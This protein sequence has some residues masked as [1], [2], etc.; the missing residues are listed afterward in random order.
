M[1]A[2]PS[3][4]IGAQL[5]IVSVV[6]ASKPMK[7]DLAGPTR[8]RGALRSALAGAG[9][10]VKA[11]LVPGLAVM[12]ASVPFMVIPPLGAMILV[13]GAALT[14][15]GAITGAGLGAAGGALYGALAVEPASNEASAALRDAL[16]D[17]TLLDALR[18]RVEEV[19][20]ERTRVRFARISTEPA[21]AEAELDPAGLSGAPDTILEVALQSLELKRVGDEINAPLALVVIARGQLRRGDGHVLGEHVVASPSDPRTIAEWTADNASQFRAYLAI[22]ADHLAGQLVDVLLVPWSSEEVAR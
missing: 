22:A 2:P 14:A 20:R 16:A 7:T 15:A 5:G 17:S 10:G 11:G 19:A 9:S 3:P 1:V 21:P 6:S 18:Q 4:E 12:Y 13:G 8:G